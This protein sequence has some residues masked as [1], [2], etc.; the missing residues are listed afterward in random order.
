MRKT[1]AI[2]ITTAILTLGVLLLARSSGPG[3][4]TVDIQPPSDTVQQKNQQTTNTF[5]KEEIA[6]HSTPTD[7]WT[8]IDGTIYNITSYIARHEG[9]KEILRAC[10]T[11]ATSL[12][13]SRQTNDGKVIG[14]GTPHSDMAESRLNQLKIG[15]L[16][17]D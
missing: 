13:K 6:K 9:G 8:I 14:T 3:S 17:E 4:T 12:F 7:C 2:F 1:A 15:T 16:S 5:T 11:D 10:G